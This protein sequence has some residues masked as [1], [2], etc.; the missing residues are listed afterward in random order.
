MTTGSTD[1]D[2]YLADIPGELV[3]RAQQNMDFAIRLLNR[4]TRQSA[5]DEAGL[6][7]AD[8]EL[9]R[10]HVALDHIAAMS[11]QEVLQAL[12]DLSV[13]RMV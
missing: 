1:D 2:D 9:G 13:T 8:D 4:E 10:L 7:L 5:L 12:K 6:E 11:F 3:V